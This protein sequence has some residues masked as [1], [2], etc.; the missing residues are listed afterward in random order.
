MTVLLVHYRLCS[1]VLIRCKLLDSGGLKCLKRIVERNDRNRR[2]GQAVSRLEG[3]RLREC[4]ELVSGARPIRGKIF[5][6]RMQLKNVQRFIAVGTFNC[7]YEFED[8][9]VRTFRAPRECLTFADGDRVRQAMSGMRYAI[10]SAL[11]NRMSGF[12]FEWRHSLFQKRPAI[13]AGEARATAMRK[14]PRPTG[15]ERKS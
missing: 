8:N 7:T 14:R 15:R 11:G 3:F 13:L 2:R 6:L 9:Q 5:F 12:K 10:N 1:V 4:R